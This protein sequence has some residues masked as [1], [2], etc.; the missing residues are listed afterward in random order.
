MKIKDG[1]KCIRKIHVLWIQNT[2]RPYLRWEPL[3]KGVH[4][5][6]NNTYSCGY[7]DEPT[8]LIPQALIT[9]YVKNQCRTASLLVLTQT[10]LSHQNI[11]N[12]TF[13]KVIIP[14]TFNIRKSINKKLFINRWSWCLHNRLYSYIHSRVCTPIVSFPIPIDKWVCF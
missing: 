13:N 8:D 4:I 11:N 7:R 6:R 14:N 3:Y 5:D 2:I 1:K 12:N 10:I 9:Y